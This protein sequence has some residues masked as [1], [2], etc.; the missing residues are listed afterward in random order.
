[1]CAK[2]LAFQWRL[3]LFQLQSF[4]EI[5]TKPMNA[6]CHKVN[7]PALCVQWQWLAQTILPL[8]RY[9]VVILC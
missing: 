1:M 7:L 9:I 8:L 2:L 3:G 4:V 5:C 6:S